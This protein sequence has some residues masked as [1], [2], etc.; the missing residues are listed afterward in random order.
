MAKIDL[1]EISS[2]IKE[3]IKKLSS[4]TEKGCCWQGTCGW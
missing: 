1:T 2:L 3:T 4:R